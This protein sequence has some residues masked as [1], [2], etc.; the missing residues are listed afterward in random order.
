[1][2]GCDRVPPRLALPFRFP[3]SHL[4]LDLTLARV[5]WLDATG[6]AAIR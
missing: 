5:A 6:R 3:L 4:H 2:Q 1:L